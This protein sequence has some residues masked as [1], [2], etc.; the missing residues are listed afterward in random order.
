MKTI[1]KYH[2]ENGKVVMPKNAKILSVQMQENQV[3]FWALID[4]DQKETEIR[5]I[6]MYGTGDVVEELDGYNHL[7]TIQDCSFVWH[8]FEKTSAFDIL[9]N[10]CP[11]VI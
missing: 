8:F 11:N 9:M 3:T 6:K 10:R 2:Y 4:T 1:Y 5:N 7:G